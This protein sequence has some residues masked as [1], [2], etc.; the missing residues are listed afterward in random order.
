MLVTHI[1]LSIQSNTET[2]YWGCVCY[3][4]LPG[5]IIGP[6]IKAFGLNVISRAFTKVYIDTQAVC[7]IMCVN[8]EAVEHGVYIMNWF[9]ETFAVVGPLHWDSWSEFPKLEH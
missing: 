7:T 1:D 2:K 3:I 5:Y 8:P 4:I 6:V 9:T